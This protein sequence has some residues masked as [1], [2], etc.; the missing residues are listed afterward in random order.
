MSNAD[1]F[2]RAFGAAI[3]DIRQKLVEEPWFGRPVT[4]PVHAVQPSLAEAMGWATSG[5]HQREPSAQPDKGKAHEIE[6]WV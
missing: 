2:A 4:P 1:W 5:D 6:R 3:T